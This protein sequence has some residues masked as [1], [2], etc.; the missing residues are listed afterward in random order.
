MSKKDY[1]AK[2][3]LSAQKLSQINTELEFGYDPTDDLDDDYSKIF[4]SSQI[5]RTCGSSDVEFVGD[6]FYHCDDCGDTWGDD[7][8]PINPELGGED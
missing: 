6:A 1:P 2:S 5:C 8:P 4:E 7:I 3:K